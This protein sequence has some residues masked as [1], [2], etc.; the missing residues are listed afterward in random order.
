MNA[1]KSV[2]ATFTTGTNPPPN[3]DL[4][5]ARVMFLG[6][7]NTEIYHQYFPEIARR[8][9][10]N[11]TYVGR[12]PTPQV[13]NNAYGGYIFSRMLNPAGN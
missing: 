12:D 6:D 13:R 8:A 2:G 5:N 11:F 1:N 7:S 10:Y 3:V 4:K 9:G